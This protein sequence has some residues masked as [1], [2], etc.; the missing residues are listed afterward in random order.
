[1]DEKKRSRWKSSS[2]RWREVQGEWKLG[3]KMRRTLTGEDR[4]EEQNSCRHLEEWKNIL[5]QSRRWKLHVSEVKWRD[6]RTS[7]LGSDKCRG[8]RIFIIRRL[9]KWGAVST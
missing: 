7:L 1:M 9:E 3:E 5:H 8:R 6:G 4:K 2:D